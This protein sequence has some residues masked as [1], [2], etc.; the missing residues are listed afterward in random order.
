[1]MST[2]LLIAISSPLRRRGLLHLLVR[3]PRFTVVAQC[4]DAAGTLQALRHLQPDVLLIDS[5][6]GRAVHQPAEQADGI[7]RTLLLG[8]EQHVG[9]CPQSTS[10]PACGFANDSTD[11]AAL[12]A[13]LTTL[14]DCP[15]SRAQ[16]GCAQRALRASL[17]LPP[18]GLSPREY[19]VFTR[20]GRGE[21]VSAI[22]MALGVSIKTV[23]SFRENIKQKLGL[24]SA[25]A[26]LR[27]AIAWQAGH[28]VPDRHPHED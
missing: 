5:A 25:H 1:M 2:R 16:S 11:E 9:L 20:I 26:L 6:I 10:N 23:E 17:Q 8:P 18:L 13:M 12:E 19:Q 3:L 21:G 14:A 15:K 7:P 22:A 24:E 27:A 28:F 4:A